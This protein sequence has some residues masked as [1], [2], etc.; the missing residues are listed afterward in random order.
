MVSIANL[1]YAKKILLGLG[2]PFKPISILVWEDDIVNNHA[3]T[4]SHARHPA[5]IE[6]FPKKAFIEDA[7]ANSLGVRFLG[8]TSLVIQNGDIWKRH[9]KIANPGKFLLYFYHA[10]ACLLVFSFLTQ[11]LNP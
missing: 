11:C 2:G 9:R 5:L 3:L 8:S 1:E 7:Y 4:I 10:C 6:T